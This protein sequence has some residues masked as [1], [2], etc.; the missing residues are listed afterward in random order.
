MYQLLWG[1]LMGQEEIE[2]ESFKIVVNCFSF[3]PILTLGQHIL[4]GLCFPPH[5][6][7]LHPQHAAVDKRHCLASS[8]R[9]SEKIE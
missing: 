8:D 7:P 5:P 3:H 2:Y 9:H 6:S 4:G 1:S